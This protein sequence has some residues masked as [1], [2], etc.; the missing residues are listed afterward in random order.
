MNIRDNCGLC[1]LVGESIPFT[2][3]KHQPRLRD[4][5]ALVC[6]SALCGL[7]IGADKNYL[8]FLGKNTCGL[9][10]GITALFRMESFT[11]ITNIPLAVE[12]AIPAATVT[13]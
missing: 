9:T 11:F 13:S 8:F 5:K 2:Q 7:C 12:R 4:A 10:I 3:R 1:N 6:V